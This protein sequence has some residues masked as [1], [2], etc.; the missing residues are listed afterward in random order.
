M[1]FGRGEIHQAAFADKIDSFAARQHVGVDKIAHVF[2]DLGR[3][4]F[5]RLQVDFNIEVAGVADHYAIFHR[6]QMIFGDDVHVAGE[7]DEKIADLGR[8]FHRHH[9]EAVHGRFQ[10]A[11]RIDFGDDHLGTHAPCPGGNAFAAP[12]IAGDNDALAGDEHICCANNAVDGRL[13]RTV[14]V[15]EEMFGRRIVDRNNRNFQGTVFFERAQANDSGSGLFHARDQVGCKMSIISVQERDEIRAII[16]G[17]HRLVIERGSQM[18]VVSFVILP[19]DSVNRNFIVL[20]ERSRHVVLC[21]QRIGC[22]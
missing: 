14:A 3:K 17:N 20:H 10:R 5:Q 1:A 11:H 7:R 8:F 15:V 6:L 19:F 21:R 9:F 22:A 18:A 13:S 4:F 12:T 2:L 16:H